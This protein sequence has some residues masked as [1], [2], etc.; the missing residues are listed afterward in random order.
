MSELKERL[1]EKLERNAIKSELDG[2]T[3]YLRKSKIPILGGDWSQIHP[4]INEDG[5]WNIINLIFG[6]KRNLKI[7]LALLAVSTMILFAFKEVFA[8]YEALR[9][10]PCVQNCLSNLYIIK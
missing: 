6:G 10:L 8:G 5:S 4:P 1:L 7:L 3:V 9:N 2:E